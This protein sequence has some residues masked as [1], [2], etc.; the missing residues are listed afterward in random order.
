[1]SRP[2]VIQV[3]GVA[4][5]VSLAIVLEACGGGGGGSGYGSA[6]PHLPPVAN[7][8]QITSFTATPGTIN[9]GES[10]V[11]AWTS[12]NTTDCSMVAEGGSTT[13]GSLTVA[14][15]T[16]NTSF[17]LSCDGAPGTTEA[18]AMASVVVIPPPPAS[19]YAITT[20]GPG[21]PGVYNDVLWDA[22]HEVLYA[23]MDGGSAINPNTETVIDPTTGALGPSV[24]AAGPAVELLQLS[25]TSFAVLSPNGQ[26]M[27]VS[28]PQFAL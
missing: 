28:S 1:M 17:E 11:L 3:Y 25:A 9:S 14:S 2:S 22:S 24:F 21:S 12:T 16:Q 10:V 19:S 27:L 5:A 15:L 7:Q 23:A 26:L 18:T 8:P 13:S 6:P 4:T 20:S